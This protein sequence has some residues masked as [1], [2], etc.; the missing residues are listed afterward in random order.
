[1]RGRTGEREHRGE[2][3]RGSLEEDIEKLINQ[4]VLRDFKCL[5]I[6]ARDKRI[7]AIYLCTLLG[8]GHE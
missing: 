1:M 6:Q 8:L 2:R 7:K 4:Y 3:E 5:K